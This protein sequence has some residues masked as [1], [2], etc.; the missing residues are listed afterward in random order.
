MSIFEKIQDRLSIIEVIEEY[1]PVIDRGNYYVALCPFHKEKRPSLSINKEK[2]VFYCFGCMAAGNMFSFV[3]QI[4]N[5]SK[6]EALEKL[7]A[8]AGVT[9]DERLNNELDEGFKLLENIASIYNQVLHM[10]LKS[11]NYISSYI[12]NRKIATSIIDNFSLGYAPKDG[13]LIGFLE[14]HNISKDLAF[15]VGLL[16]FKDGIY[17]DKFSDRLV[18]PIRNEYGKVVGF[19]ARIFS[20][21]NTGRPKY[22]NSPESKYFN[23]S[24]VLF[25]LDKAKKSIQ[26]NKKVVLVEGNMDVI[27]AHQNELF[28]TIATQGTST[29]Q[30][31]INKI[32]RLNCDLILAFDNDVA[33]KTAE[34]KVLKMALD[35]DI[36]VFKMQISDQ[37]KDIDEYLQV[38]NT[39][40]IQVIPYLEYL[41]SNSNNLNSTDLYTQKS[42]INYILSFISNSNPITQA[43]VISML[44]KKSGLD[45]ATLNKISNHKKDKTQDLTQ[46]SININP[47][48]ASF[49]QI[50]ALDTNNFNLPI[51]YDVIKNTLDYNMPTYL[52]YINQEEIKWVITSEQKKYANVEVNISQAISNLIIN[53]RRHNSN[54]IE[55]KRQLSLIKLETTNH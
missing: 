3:S 18:I 45:L 50:L 9:L 35:N 27:T 23:K 52:E 40:E 55:V 33:G 17:K 12:A 25:G 15:N 51:I 49:Y 22:L 31:H 8:K 24:K 38:H 20:N 48:K 13:F 16:T 28:H 34:H 36:N 30:E 42:T 43:Q 39:N 41:I 1:T 14:K 6:K 54:N 32:K 4:D 29:T 19:T 21:D 53:L 11:D 5:I 7:A 26:T 47:I 37:Y 2:G 10:Y 46:T 44:S